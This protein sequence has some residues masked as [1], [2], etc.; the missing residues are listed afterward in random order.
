[1]RAKEY[2]TASRREKTKMD[3]RRFYVRFMER[4]PGPGYIVSQWP[5]EIGILALK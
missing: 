5:I 2:D 4:N 1:M 3:Q